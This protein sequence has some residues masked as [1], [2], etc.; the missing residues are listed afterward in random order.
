MPKK[1]FTILVRLTGSL[2]V[3]ATT[4]VICHHFLTVNATTVGFAYL[5]GVLAIATAW[6]FLPA[7][8]ASVSAM[9]CFNFFFL[10]PIGQFTIADPQNW[11]ALF[12][13]LATALVA[14]HLS[15]RARRQALDALNRQRETEQLYALSRSILLSESSAP[16]VSR[17]VQHVAQIFECDAVALFDA[18]NGEVLCGGPEEIAGIEAA[19]RQAVTLSTNTRDEERR[20]TVAV[21]NLGGRP[22]GSL[23]LRGSEL[24]DGA[25]QALLNLVAIALER[26]RTSEAA[27]RAEVARESEEFKST[28]LDAIAHEFKTPLTSIKAASTSILSDGARLSP[29]LMELTTII[30]EETDRLSLLVTEAVRMSQIDA[31]KVRLDRK[32][33]DLKPLLETLAEQFAPRAEGRKLT[34]SVPKKMSRVNADSDLILLALRQLIENALKYSP[35]GTP[36]EIVAGE[37]PGRIVVRVIDLGAGVPIKERERIFDKYYRLQ[38]ARQTSPGTGLGLYIAREIMRTHGGD[39]WVESMHGAG[40]EFCAAIPVA[41]PGD[42]E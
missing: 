26:V 41:E 39:L 11:I 34:L 32:R 42:A 18:Y 33:F 8:V 40:S 20:L 7:S 24:Q 2:T 31:G 22:I 10:P 1:L 19:L 36:V 13:F 27:S 16:V 3:V 4:T 17:L 37:E 23:A 28:L 9:L 15:D 5:M 6:G 30:D 35:Q 12:T 25:L 21:I 29:Q 38:S 14:S